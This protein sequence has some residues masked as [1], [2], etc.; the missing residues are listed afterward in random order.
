[1]NAIIGSISEPYSQHGSHELP[2]MGHRQTLQSTFQMPRLRKLGTRS[3]HRHRRVLLHMWH[4]VLT[5]QHHR[6]SKYLR[7]LRSRRSSTLTRKSTCRWRHR[8]RFR[9]PTRSTASPRY[10]LET[11]TTSTPSASIHRRQPSDNSHRRRL[12]V[13]F[14]RRCTSLWARQAAIRRRQGHAFRWETVY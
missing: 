11:A 5:S 3:S 2:C 7:R 13:L 6:L 9:Q 1:M 10:K 12:P 14:W 8:R 4:Q